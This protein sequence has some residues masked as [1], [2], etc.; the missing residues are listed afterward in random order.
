MFLFLKLMDNRVLISLIRTSSMFLLH[1]SDFTF[2]IV[3][4]QISLF[5]K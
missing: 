3:L 5:N 1:G 4:S 2:N